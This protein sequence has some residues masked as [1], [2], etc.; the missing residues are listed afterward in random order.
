SGWCWFRDFG[1]PDDFLNG[2]LSN[3]CPDAFRDRQ[4]Q[5]EKSMTLA[6]R[7]DRSAPTFGFATRSWPYREAVKP[8]TN[9]P[10]TRRIRQ[11]IP[12]SRSL[13]L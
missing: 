4:T 10:R 1:S 9:P 7:I 12:Q 2:S 6:S 13:K 8:R 3:D 11:S 5:A